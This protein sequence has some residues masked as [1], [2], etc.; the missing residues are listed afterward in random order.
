MSAST[1]VRHV[2]VGKESG[3]AAFRRE[4]RID[5]HQLSGVSTYLVSGIGTL[6]SLND[7]IGAMQSRP[8]VPSAGTVTS[9]T[10]ALSLSDVYRERVTSAER[11]AHDCI[12]LACVSSSGLSAALIDRA[13]GHDRNAAGS[14]AAVARNQAT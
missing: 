14:V 7:D 6:L 12:L 2:R 5:R 8:A 3:P 9:D 10:P 13:I 4:Y 1:A 11:A